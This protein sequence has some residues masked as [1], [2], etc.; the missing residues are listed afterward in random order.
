MPENKRFLP[1]MVDLHDRT[2]VIFGGGSVG[3]RK[4]ELFSEYAN[5]IVVSRNFSHRLSELHDQDLVTLIRTDAG[6]LSD[7]NIKELVDDAF[8]VI[9]A[10][11]N[12][13]INDRI[14]SIARSLNILTNQ[15]D[16]IGEITIPAV[17]HRGDLVIGISTSGASP[18][19][20]RYV[21]QKIEKVITPEYEQMIILQNDIRNYLKEHVK[22]QKHRR[23]ILWKVLE[24]P[25]VWEYIAGSYEKAYKRAYD[26]VQEQI[27]KKD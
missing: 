21:R 11:S 14:T 6:T 15:V 26:I 7:N 13:Q 17:I 24:D 8:L 18:A 4:A 3:E 19:F 1:L 25:I 5:T 20:S 9:P 12:R 23:S 16:T 27:N 22:E 10:T 2:V